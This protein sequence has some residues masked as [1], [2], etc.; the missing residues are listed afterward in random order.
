[1][2]FR[3]GELQCQLE[4]TR[5]SRHSNFSVHLA[6][7]LARLVKESWVEYVAQELSNLSATARKEA[8]DGFGPLYLRKIRLE[9]LV[10]NNLCRTRAVLVFLGRRSR[11]G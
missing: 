3:T 9:G 6:L 8:P 2:Q 5:A 10:P 4:Q 11:E 7:L 1:M